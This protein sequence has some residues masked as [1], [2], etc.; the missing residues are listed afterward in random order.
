MPFDD[1]LEGDSE[2]GEA[3]I[4]SE[5]SS[6]DRARIRNVA[7]ALED[8]LSLTAKTMSL[9][10]VGLNSQELQRSVVVSKPG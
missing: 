6:V 9:P 1:D 2:F 8:Q 7:N 10:T 4:L 3:Q 5:F